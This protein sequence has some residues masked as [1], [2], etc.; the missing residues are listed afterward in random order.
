MMTPETFMER[1]GITG[2]VSTINGPRIN[3]A[4]V[5]TRLK[6]RERQ[7][8]QQRAF[9]DLTTY[10]A[11]CFTYGSGLAPYLCKQESLDITRRLAPVARLARIAGV[12][13][14][15]RAPAITQARTLFIAFHEAGVSVVAEPRGMV[16]DM[17]RL[18]RAA[19]V[20]WLLSKERYEVIL[21]PEPSN[22]V[23]GREF[24]SIAA[25]AQMVSHPT[26]GMAIVVR[27]FG[28]ECEERV[29]VSLATAA[30]N[31]LAEVFGNI[32]EPCP[33]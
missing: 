10:T 11:H 7:G 4:K 5:N 23:W 28:S 20:P 1:H 9:I 31:L 17:D 6:L 18:V 12:T 8:I 21:R 3:V 26:E 24:A 25:F 22:A 13:T 32:P 33:A 29:M 14:T 2:H 16:L 15:G 19:R 27:P 30:Q